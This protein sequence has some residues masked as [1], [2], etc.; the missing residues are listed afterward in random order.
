MT[1]ISRIAL[2]ALVVVSLSAPAAAQNAVTAADIQRLEDN[3]YLAERDVQQLRGRDATQSSQL[4]A[5]VDELREEV[6]Y[7]KVKLRKERSLAR[8]EFADVRDRIE[9]V[10]ARARGD[11]TGR[12]STAPP[13]APLPPARTAGGRTGTGAGAGRVTEIPAGTEFDARLSTELDSETAVV[14]DR[15]E[16]TTMSDVI[17]NRRTVIPAGSMMR[18]VIT[19]VE[20]ATRTDRDSRLTL[21]FDQVTIGG[22][23]YPLRGTVADI[24]AGGVKDEAVRTG[25]GGGVGA[26][27]GGILGGVKGAVIGGVIGAGGTIAAT[28][29]KNVK[30]PQGTVLRVRIDSPAQIQA[31]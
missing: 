12:Y 18:G 28:E 22:R 4:Q 15:F 23:A 3:V 13:A 25:V 7:L 21:A 8:T 19:A 26:I 16:A 17:I 24:E 27:I 11:A 10:R 31:R 5:Q 30:L 29:G 1:V 20:R 9:D 6:I 2:A 14:E